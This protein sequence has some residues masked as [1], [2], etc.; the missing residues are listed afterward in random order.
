M[1]SI[2]CHTYVVIGAS[3]RVC[4][5]VGWLMRKEVLLLVLLEKLRESQQTNLRTAPR[6]ADLPDVFFCSIISNT[7]EVSFR[8]EW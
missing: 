3:A 6:T 4:S 5:P 7:S 8:I 2:A 1:M